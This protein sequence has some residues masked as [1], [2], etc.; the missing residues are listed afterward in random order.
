MVRIQSIEG[1]AESRDSNPQR[2]AFNII[3][4]GFVIKPTSEIIISLLFYII[5]KN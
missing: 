3:K 2:G 5:I 4:Y 1:A